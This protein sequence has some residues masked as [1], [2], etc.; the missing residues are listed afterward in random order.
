MTT[1]RIR[2]TINPALDAGSYVVNYIVNHT[3]PPLVDGKTPNELSGIGK[4]VAPFRV[5]DPAC[6]SGSFLIQAYQFLLDWYRDAYV[7]DDPSKYAKGKSPRLYQAAK[8]EW[9][10]TIAERRRILLTHIFGVDID[11]QAVEVTKLS[12]LLKV[13]EG[14]SGDQ[15]ARQ[16]DLFH[17]RAL[18]DLSTNIR[19]GNSIRVCS[20]SAAQEL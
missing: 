11:P 15:I 10:L 8:G 1:R 20:Q 6:G 12:L 9:R 19:C 3:L 17:M 4:R 14:E 13:L 5:L 2:T 18:P 16:M 7:K